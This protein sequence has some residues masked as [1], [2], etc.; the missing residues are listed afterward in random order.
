M[1]KLFLLLSSLIMVIGFTVVGN[2]AFAEG[3]GGQVQTNGQI[4]FYEDEPKPSSSEP[5]VSS[6]SQEPVPSVSSSELPVTK[7]AGKYPSTGELVKKSL[8]IS[9][10]ALIV[11]AFLL[12]LY[13]RRKKEAEE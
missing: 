7:P 2:T 8:S 12:F 9:G 1:K 11:A 4:T 5:P 3:N 13:K 6:S 10:A